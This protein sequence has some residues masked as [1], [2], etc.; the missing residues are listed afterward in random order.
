MQ[1]QPQQIYPQMYPQMYPQAM[2]APRPRSPWVPNCRSG[3]CVVLG[4]ILHCIMAAVYA[5]LCFV[6]G[7]F[8]A[9]LAPLFLGVTGFL[10]ILG[11]KNH[12][13][14]LTIAGIV[15][16]SITMVASIPPVLVLSASFYYYYN[17]AFMA[18]IISFNVVT[19]N[20]LLLIISLS[21]YLRALHTDFNVNTIHPPL[22]MPPVYLT[23][24]AS[25]QQ[26]LVPM[27][28]MPMPMYMARP[29]V[30]PSAA[31]AA[32]APAQ[33]TAGV[34]PIYPSLTMPTAPPMPQPIG[35]VAM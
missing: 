25:G 3:K 27:E 16:N 7:A 28:A 33:Q 17:G 13:K 26:V 4:S 20:A 2:V 22:P 30:P 31:P 24:T 19:I 32:P 34:M 8:P 14:G 11:V 10:P 9:L 18:L 23:T 21:I 5:V 12:N 1:A 6:S 29:A 15:L 35:A